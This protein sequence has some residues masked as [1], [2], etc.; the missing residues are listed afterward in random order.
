[1]KISNWNQ[2]QVLVA[3]EFNTEV[4]SLKPSLGVRQEAF[5]EIWVSSLQILI[6]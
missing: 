4:P 6:A 5:N 3:S 2:T 1:M